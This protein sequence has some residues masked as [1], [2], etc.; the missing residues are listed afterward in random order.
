MGKRIKVQRRGRGSPT[1]RATK[2]RKRGTVKHPTLSTHKDKPL[3]GEI[4]DLEHERGRSAPLARIQYENGKKSYMIAPEGIS[5][6]EEIRIG[7]PEIKIG[8]TL[9]LKDI[10]EGTSIFNIES[11]PGDGGKFVRAGGTY[12]TVVTRD[13]SKVIVKLP[14]G[15]SKQCNPECRASIGVVAGGGRTEKPFV[16]AG[17]KFHHCRAK[18]QKWPVN[19]GVAMI[20]ASHPHGGGQKQHIGKKS[21]C[22]SRNAP[23]GRKVGLIAARRTGRKKK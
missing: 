13:P 9:P 21:S 4:I 2:K 16:K 12:A 8:N 15:K 20:A 3:E 18:N 22:V 17:N 10:P 1:F 14:S 7:S 23:P 6:G 11:Q 19:R 5:I